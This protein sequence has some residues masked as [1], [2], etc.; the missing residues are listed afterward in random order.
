MAWQ[1]G[2]AQ[3]CAL[4][5]CVPVPGEQDPALELLLCLGPHRP[6]R[7]GVGALGKGVPVLEGAVPSLWAVSA[8]PGVSGVVPSV[9]LSPHPPLVTS[10][11]C[12]Q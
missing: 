7:L 10:T 5:P 9:A 2:R 3:G 1:G 6:G 12:C 11:C 8:K 4:V